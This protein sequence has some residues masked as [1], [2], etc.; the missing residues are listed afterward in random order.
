MRTPSSSVE[1]SFKRLDMTYSQM[2]GI[3]LDELE[4]GGWEIC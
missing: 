2:M 3:V 4:E 1:G